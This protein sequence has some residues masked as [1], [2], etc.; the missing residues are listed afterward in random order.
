MGATGHRG[1]SPK[2]KEAI[3][4][5]LCKRIGQQRDNVL[6]VVSYIQPACEA[7]EKEQDSSS[8]IH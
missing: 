3:G 5:T 7:W 4:Y 1:W 8:G 2:T 6:L